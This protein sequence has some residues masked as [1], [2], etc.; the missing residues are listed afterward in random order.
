MGMIDF[1]LFRQLWY[2]LAL[3][4]E[5]HFG[6]AAK[7]LG[8]SQPPLT[9]QIQIL[10]QTLRVRLFER[11]RNQTTLTPQG[12]AILPAVQ[13]L[14][15]QAARLESIVLDARQGSVEQVTIGAINSAI[16]GILPSVIRDARELFPKANIALTELYSATAWAR[17]N[18]KEIDIAF[19]RYDRGTDQVKVIQL[20]HNQL[21]AAIPAHH[22]LAKKDAVGLYDL[23]D[24]NWVMLNR[25]ASPAYFDSVTM[26]CRTQGFSPRVSHHVSSQHSQMAFVVC[27][28]GVALVPRNNAI[29]YPSGVVFKPLVE[30]L[31]IATASVAWIA[32]TPVIKAIIELSQGKRI[33][34]HELANA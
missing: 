25:E 11:S 23:K 9:Q 10:E 2:F 26:A 22:P 18:S 8:I 3:A 33:L 1:R 20:G 27:G 19:G 30:H 15:D 14:A 31:E 6:R 24:D 5:R 4:E 29:T 28:Y 7:R 12:L 34:D 21:D 13:R 17:L 16:I 32:E